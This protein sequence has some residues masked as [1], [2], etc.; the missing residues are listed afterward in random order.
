[1]NQGCAPDLVHRFLTE[2][3]DARALEADAACLSKVPRPGVFHLP[4]P[5]AP[6]PL[7][8]RAAS[9]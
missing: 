9:R 2:D 8:A 5:L 7:P 4:D 6:A 1:M 3:D